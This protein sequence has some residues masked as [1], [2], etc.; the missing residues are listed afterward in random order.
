MGRGEAEG[1]GRKWRTE[2]ENTAQKHYFFTFLLLIKDTKL[3]LRSLHS[4]IFMKKET[5]FK[6]TG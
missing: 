4:V 5:L 6:H 1:N 2:I 3:N